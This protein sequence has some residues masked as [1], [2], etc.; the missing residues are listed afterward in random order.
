MKAINK[1]ATS[2]LAF[3]LNDVILYTQ[4][5]IEL[6]IIIVSH[7]LLTGGYLYGFWHSKSK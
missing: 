7:M 4:L 3:C 6:S 2:Q 5:D 1:I